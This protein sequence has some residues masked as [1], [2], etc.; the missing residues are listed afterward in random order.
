MKKFVHIALTLGAVL[1]VPT[2]ASAQQ[3]IFGEV[4]SED[5]QFL[6]SLNPDRMDTQ[7]ICNQVGDYG[8]RVGDGIFSRLGHYGSRFN[9]DGVYNPNA[10]KPPKV[11]DAYGRARYRVTV[12][13]RLGNDI[14]PE[15]LR[16]VACSRY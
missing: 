10:R 6:G 13:T 1:I 15:R 5:G 8:S 9:P 7:S 2:A 12:N 14:S 4:R 11:Y 3:V 16:E